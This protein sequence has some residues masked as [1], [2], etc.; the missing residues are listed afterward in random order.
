MR[1]TR[2]LLVLLGLAL[3]GAIMGAVAGSIVTVSVGVALEGPRAL[4]HAFLY[5]AGAV[6]G[7]ICGAVLAPVASFAFL[8]HVP[9]WRVFVDTAIGT[10]VGGVATALLHVSVPL[11]LVAG[12]AGF[13]AAA[14][15]LAWRTPRKQPAARPPSGG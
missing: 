2:I 1:A 6:F 8:R 4:G 3:A 10:I 5:G 7:A 12:T 9:L 15:R 13:F 14:A 11:V